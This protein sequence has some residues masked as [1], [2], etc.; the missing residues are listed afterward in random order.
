MLSVDT[1]LSITR[2]GGINLR[3]DYAIFVQTPHHHMIVL[4]E[5]EDEAEAMKILP[6]PIHQQSGTL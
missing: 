4:E 2:W 1:G 6:P 3:F 5:E